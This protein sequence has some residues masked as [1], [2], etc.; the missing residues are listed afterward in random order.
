MLAL[1]KLTASDEEA[2]NRAHRA[3]AATDPTFARGFAADM[4]FSDYLAHLENE[5]QGSH[6]P[7]SYVPST[8]YWG[9]IG[10]ELVGRL[11]LRHRLNER[12]VQTGG[13]IGYVVLPEYR[14][15]GLATE[16]LRSALPMARARGLERVLITCDED[17]IASRRVI[18]KCG[19]V[20]ESTS[21]IP[22]TGVIQRRYWISLQ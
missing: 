18:E 3:T 7:A 10:R 1:R 15:R 8:M 12:L 2:F 14:Q 5:E 20:F 4:S 22:E 21:A 17:N 9:F 16:M 19:G 11:N 13:N 6:L